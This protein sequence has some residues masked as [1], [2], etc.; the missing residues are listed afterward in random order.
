[1]LCKT[2]KRKTKHGKYVT[3][4]TMQERKKYRTCFP[5]KRENMHMSKSQIKTLKCPKKQNKKKAEK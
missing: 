3:F 5:V 4:K 1:M 2:V